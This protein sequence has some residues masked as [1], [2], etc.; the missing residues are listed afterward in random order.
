M[1]GI[2]L[3]TDAIHAAGLPDGEYRSHR[4]GETVR[5][6]NGE[7]RTADG[8]VAGST[9]TM[10]RAIGN[11]MEFSGVS[12]AEAVRMA[13]LTPARATGADGK[14]SL[15]PGKDADL[16]VFSQEFSVEAT[17]VGGQVVFRATEVLEET[18]R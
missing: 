5:I 1:E 18:G 13:T 15:V 8:T 4:H 12:V 9:L 16:V 7:S 10:D 17:V 14:G 2:S 11:I 3:V 6:T